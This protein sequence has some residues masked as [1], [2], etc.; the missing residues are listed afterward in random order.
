MTNAALQLPS[1]PSPT[2]A[3]PAPA[4]CRWI[5]L[6][7]AV[8]RSGKV[9]GHWARLC[10]KKYLA[11]GLAR[12]VS[13]QGKRPFWEIR[14]DA[15]PCLARVKTVD[16]LNR[17]F[18]MNVL[19]EAQRK[20]LLFKESTVLGWRAMKGQTDR[21][22]WDANTELYLAELARSSGTTVSRRA[23]YGWDRDYTIQ[24]RAGL[25]DKRWRQLGEV[26]PGDDQFGDF[27]K[28]LLGW[29]L[30]QNEPTKSTAY[31]LAARVAGRNGWNVPCEKTAIRFLNK[32]PRG[33]VMRGRKGAKAF[34]AAG[35]AYIKRDYRRIWIDGVEQQML[36]NDVWCGDHH[37]CDTIVVHNGKLLRPWLTAW[38][39]VRSR[40]IVGYRFA[41][42][43]PDSTSILLALRHGILSNGL[44]IPRYCYTDNG[45][46]YKS[47]TLHGWSKAELRSGR[48]DHDLMRFKGV[49][50]HL[51]IGVM[52]AIP[53][54]AKAK[55]VERFFGT[56]EQQFGKLTHTYCGRDPLHKPP[57]LIDRLKRNE[58][59]TF[60]EYVADA[61]AWIER[62]Y[63][64]QVH[65]GHAMDGLTPAQCFS[66]NLGELRTT[67]EEALRIC[68]R[69]TSEPVKV[70]RN[71]VR[72]GNFT[73][74]QGEP[75]LRPWD[76]KYVQLLVD[77]DDDTRVIVIDPDGREICEA[78]EETLAPW[79]AMP[80]DKS[81]VIHATVRRHNRA[82]ADVQKRN[83]GMRISA[84]DVLLD[85][86]VTASSAPTA[87]APKPGKPLALPETPPVLKLI[88]TGFESPSTAPN[89][90]RIAPAAEA[91]AAATV[92]TRR[93]SVM[94]KLLRASARQGETDRRASAAQ[95]SDPWAKA[96]QQREAAHG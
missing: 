9:Q 4:G 47:W 26:R 92:E 58:A 59:P 14:E 45:K 87:P 51:Q 40:K 62:C 6:K 21:G 74:G 56:F 48:I 29:Y 94:D 89:P 3:A 37:T 50:Q 19:T 42:I 66:A 11:A 36:S 5:D 65:T 75:A 84:L 60:D 90:M 34:N 88:Q 67:S 33:K 71:G 13:G 77:P 49:Y 64:Q 81:K 22:Q 73:Y 20:A 30:D 57:H 53:F 23:L 17:D 32:L 41:A 79:G 91:P 85:E 52:T 80:H 44:A 68:L 69:K 70:G 27:F 63:H 28:E 24:G 12:Q 39:D 7:Q 8:A 18:N 54:N 82:V 76:G 1:A 10:A 93:E 78:R 31:K 55:P 95:R 86:H 2:Q 43:D 61:T 15:D 35:G 25:M 38:M 83:M 46:D 72:C 16:V 96:T